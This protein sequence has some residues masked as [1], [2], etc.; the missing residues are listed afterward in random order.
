MNKPAYIL[1]LIILL[2]AACNP[3]AKWEKSDV[4]V[5]M[6]IENI[7]AGFVEC[8][9]NTD[10]ESY[11]L[12]GILPAQDDFDPMTRQKQF[13][14][15][16][17]DS[18]TIDY[19]QWRNQLLKLGEFNIA[20]FSSH[21]LRYGP[22]HQFF[23]GLT[24]NRDYWVYSFAVNPETLKPIGRLNLTTIHTAEKSNIDAHFEYRIK[25]NWD[26]IYPVDSDGK[27]MTDFPYIATTRDSA[28]LSPHYPNGDS[29]AYS[30]LMA[31]I[32]T[33]FA[34]PKQARIL[35]GVQVIENDGDH[36]FLTFEEGHT[37]YTAISSFDG[38][39]DRATIYKFV[40]HG[41][42]TEYFFTDTDEANIAN[43]TNQAGK[44]PA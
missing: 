8:Q 43:T 6:H 36:S 17:I 28:L 44:L 7:S 14:L 39:F 4:N 13:M 1:L 12:T 24:A 2:T 11:Y 15:L 35:Y 20:P 30:E 22:T 34:Y 9:F 27:L 38:K 41:E 19:L 23:T 10:K 37:Y 21:T 5:Q 29:I 25:G 40:W 3:E 16:A 31:W 33:Q 42:L 32:E 18:A 26:Y